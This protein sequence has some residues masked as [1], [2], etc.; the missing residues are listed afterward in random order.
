MFEFL[1]LGFA[2]TQ[3]IVMTVIAIYTWFIK[4]QSASANEMLDLRLRVVELE[5]S[6]KD[7]P[8]KVEIEK[9]QGQVN[10]V[11]KQLESVQHSV[12][13]IEDYLLNNKK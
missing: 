13:R 10:S 4:K 7:M 2:E 12:H 9:L 8:S 11:G 5:N 1:K 6:I 3:W